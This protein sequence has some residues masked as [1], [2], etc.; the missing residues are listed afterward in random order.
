MKTDTDDTGSSAGRSG[1]RDRAGGRLS[2]AKLPGP[3]LYRDPNL[4]VIF[5]VTLSAVLSVSS[6]TPAF[7]KI[8]RALE[9]SPQSIGLLIS[10][11]TVPGVLL[12]PVLGVLADRWGRK[13]IL[14]PSL[15]LYGIAGGACGLARDFEILLGLRFLQGVG[16][17]S[18]GTLNVT[19]IGDLYSGTARTAAMG[20]NSSVLS[21]GTASWPAIGGALATLA[22][23]APF[24]LPLLALPVAFLVLLRLEN[25]EP[26]GGQEL[27]AYL[28]AVGRSLRSVRTIGLFAASTVTFILIFGPYLAYLPVLIDR[29][30]AASSFTIGII[31]SSASLASGLSAS[32]LGRVS[33]H[34]SE[35]TLVVLG[36][37]AYV[38]VFLCIPLA[39]HLWLLLL[40][41]V[42]F[43]FA[44]GLAIPSIF[45]LLVG[46][47]PGRQRAAFMSVNGMVLRLGQ[48]LGPLL[49]GLLVAMAGT[50]AAFFGGAVL[51]AGMGVVAAATI[52]R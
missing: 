18:L 15:L 3:P 37:A 16:A 35:K 11:F 28:A 14:V 38:A 29:S 30:F 8:A 1:I 42:V 52:R 50:E 44:N 17:A 48:T 36:Y 51:A 9:I 12:T 34:I 20:Y 27:R 21:A 7:P 24:F 31:M 4:L 47:A 19:L 41:A 45:T 23:Y 2:P 10:A 39:G 26:D 6:L 46:L 43:G 40:P 13:R 5:A 33:R 32:Q 49:A 25:P 22:W